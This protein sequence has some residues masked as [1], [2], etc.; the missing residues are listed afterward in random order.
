MILC[1]YIPEYWQNVFQNAIGCTLGSLVAVWIAVAIYRRQTRDAAMARASVEQQE[2][3]DLLRYFS[4][5]LDE[6]V[7]MLTDQSENIKNYIDKLQKD[8][9]GDNLMTFV[10]LSSIKRLTDGNVPMDKLLI[11]YVD[12]FS[13]TKDALKTF[14]EIFAVLDYAYLELSYLPVTIER[15]LTQDQSRKLKFSE[16]Y[17]IAWDEVGSFI[18]T[19]DETDP[20]NIR[21]R[22]LLASFREGK[23]AND[24]IQYHHD[25]F[26]SPINDIALEQL[27]SGRREFVKLTI[28]T[29]DAKQLFVD[30]FRHQDNF[31]KNDL[32]PIQTKI[33]QES[34][35]L[36]ALL[37]ELRKIYS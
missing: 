11:S 16:Y 24:D 6:I 15:V 34:Q 22:E 37:E 17:K 9:L 33:L 31:I 20:A 13:H 12:N 26:I 25:R 32:L 36:K 35:K 29:R 10:P 30:M 19:L 7:R 27:A 21:L 5:S 8:P 14:S 4:I 3:N 28:T 23:A 18:T 2:Q 1:F